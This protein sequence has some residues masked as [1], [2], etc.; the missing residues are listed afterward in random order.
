MI[1]KIQLH[2]MAGNIQ[3]VTIPDIDSDEVKLQKQVDLLTL[4]LLEAKAHITAIKKQY[5]FDVMV[6]SICVNAPP[7]VT[8]GLYNG[9]LSCPMAKTCQLLYGDR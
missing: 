2:D 8:K 4:G 5:R 1:K 9:C 3:E 7:E 6:K